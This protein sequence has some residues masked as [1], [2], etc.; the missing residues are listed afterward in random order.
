MEYLVVWASAAAACALTLPSGFG[1]GTLLMPVFALFFPLDVAIAMTAVVH[2]CTNLF[3][4]VLYGRFADGLILVRFGIPAILGAF[5]GARLLFALSGMH[6]FFS[7]TLDG[8]LFHVMPVKVVVGVLLAVFVLIELLSG[9]GRVPVSDGSL[10][11]G[12]ALTGFFGGLSGHQGALR[13][14]FLVRAG[15]SKETFIATGVVIACLVD[16]SRVSVYTAY[17]AGEGFKGSG[18]MLLGAICAALLGTLAASR[19]ARDIT[20][21]GVQITVTVMIVVIACALG[22]GLV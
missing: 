19:V 20:M 5:A 2:L 11:V 10:V 3:R 6:P 4:F 9:P 1:L 17:F 21:R 22:A 8:G 14:A 7:Y 12:G 13:S 18:V 15:L 16:F